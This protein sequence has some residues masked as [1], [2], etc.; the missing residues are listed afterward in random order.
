MADQQTTQ[1][2]TQ[3][4]KRPSPADMPKRRTLTPPDPAAPTAPADIDNDLPE[5]M[6]PGW[7][8]RT[9]G[10]EAERRFLDACAAEGVD[11]REVDPDGYW[12]G[13]W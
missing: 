2:T 7:D 10:R 12:S 6:R 11:P 3:Q 13:G 5:S 4:V 9:P 8:P 1:Q